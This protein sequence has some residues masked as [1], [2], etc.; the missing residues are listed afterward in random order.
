V[1]KLLMPKVS[2]RSDGKRV[3]ELAKALLGG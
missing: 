1:M 3:S 2:G